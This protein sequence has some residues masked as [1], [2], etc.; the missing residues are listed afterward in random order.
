DQELNEEAVEC[1]RHVT[2]FMGDRKTKKDQVEHAVSLISTLLS[3][4]PALHTEVICQ[5]CKQLK[6]NPSSESRDRG[7]HLLLLTLASVPVATNLLPYFIAFL[8][9]WEQTNSKCAPLARV[10]LKAAIR[11]CKLS[12]RKELP[13]QLEI[14]SLRTPDASSS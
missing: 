2:G 14:E 8:I 7:W 12:A 5:I 1:F 10:A 11:G 3:C 4:P 6:G 9:N 13:M